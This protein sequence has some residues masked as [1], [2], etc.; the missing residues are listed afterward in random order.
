[1]RTVGEILIEARNSKKLSLDQIAKETKIR[2]KILE[3]LVANAKD[4]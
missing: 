4:F 3:I 2:K 1:M